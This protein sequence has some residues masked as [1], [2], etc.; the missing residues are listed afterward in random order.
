MPQVPSSQPL[1][2]SDKCSS[3][4]G[5]E[6]TFAIIG[7]GYSASSYKLNAENRRQV[8]AIWIVNVTRVT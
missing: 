3:R 5:K 1:D 4:L 7:F 2:R 8:D 6:L